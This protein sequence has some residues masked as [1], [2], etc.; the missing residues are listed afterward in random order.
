LIEQFGY[1]KKGYFVKKLRRN[2]VLFFCVACCTAC[3]DLQENLFLK[4]DGS[5]TFSFI[6]N[7]EQSKEMVKMLGTISNTIDSNDSIGSITEKPEIKFE[8]AFEKATYKL[9]NTQGIKNITIISDTMKYKFGISFD[10]SNISTLNTG[11]NNLFSDDAD[12]TAKKDIVYF[13]LKNN[14]LKRIET[15][16]SKSIVGKSLGLPNEASNFNAHKQFSL[17]RFLNTATFTTTYSFEQTINKA[18]NTHSILSNDAKTITLVTYPF[19]SAKDT[20]DKKISIANT[21]TLQ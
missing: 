16:D 12:T 18:Q 4:K 5:G 21:I 13:E 17:E 15:L 10:F 14:E 1:L 3:F 19:A 9:Q 6:I 11:L 20:A 7:L 2:I 8:K